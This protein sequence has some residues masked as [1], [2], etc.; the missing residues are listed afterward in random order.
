MEIFAHRKA[1]TMTHAKNIKPMKNLPT[2][3]VGGLAGSS[4]LL[5]DSSIPLRF[6]ARELGL[7]LKYV[8]F[9]RKLEPAYA[10]NI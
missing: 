8:N 6:Y 10:K 2:K 9:W 1:V 5:H 4:F 3:H 7:E